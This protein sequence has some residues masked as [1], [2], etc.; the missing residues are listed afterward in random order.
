[1]AKPNPTHVKTYFLRTVHMRKEHLA[2][3]QQDGQLMMVV[4]RG[5]TRDVQFVPAQHLF[6]EE[7][8][9]E[10]KATNRDKIAEDK[11]ELLEQHRTQSQ[12]QKLQKAA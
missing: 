9:M 6:I 3:V 2:G 1:M 11:A 7:S 5:E 8:A 4:K 12:P 10:D